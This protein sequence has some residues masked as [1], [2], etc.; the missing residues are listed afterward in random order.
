MIL[1]V[2]LDVSKERDQA[3]VIF[4]GNRVKLVLMTACAADGQAEKRFPGSAQDVVKF[5]PDGQCFVVRFIIPDT[6]PVESRGDDRVERHVRQFITSQLLE[7][8]TVVR[9]VLVECSNDV[10]TVPPGIRF[11][12]VTFVAVGF[13]VANQV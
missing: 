2:R 1:T 7:D 9:F 13:C 6:D 3:V 4:L 5:I 12:I 10:V 8:E 11:P